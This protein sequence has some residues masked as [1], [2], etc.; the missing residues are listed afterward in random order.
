MEGNTLNEF[1]NDLINGLTGEKEFVYKERYYF[2]TRDY[3]ADEKM[4]YI[5]LEEYNCIK[6][7]SELEPG[8]HLKTIKF[9]G[10]T[11]NEAVSKF[12][13][14]KVFDGKSIYEAEKD[15]VVLYG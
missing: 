14:G 11:L 3:E 5:R 13:D 6:G 2:I 7:K 12:K 15:I 9:S 10:F 1:V 8:E 4:F